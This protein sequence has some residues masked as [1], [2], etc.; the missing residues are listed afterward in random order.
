MRALAE[1][2]RILQNMIDEAEEN[3][4]LQEDSMKGHEALANIA[5]RRA[6]LAEAVA[7]VEELGASV[8]PAEIGA[9]AGV[10]EY[11]RLRAQAEASEEHPM[12]FPRTIANGV[13]EFISIEYDSEGRACGWHYET[14]KSAQWIAEQLAARPA[15]TSEKSSNIDW[16]VTAH[17][18]RARTEKVEA[19]EKALREIWTTTQ[20]CAYSTMSTEGDA[21]RDELALIHIAAIVAPFVLAHEAPKEGP[22]LVW[23][24][25]R[26]RGRAKMAQGARAAAPTE[27]EAMRKAKEQSPDR[28]FEGERLE[29]NIQLTEAARAREAPKEPDHD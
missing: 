9:Q 7:L 26:Y 10:A 14:E 12:A 18:W 24:F 16:A 4:S 29:L 2:A 19:A 11:H 28:F 17:M 22:S 23:V 25:D 15:P 13:S 20:Q 27:A 1:I 8:S 21:R 3:I 6:D 5:Q